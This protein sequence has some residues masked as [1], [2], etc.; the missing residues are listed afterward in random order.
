MV[1][2]ATQRVVQE[3]YKNHAKQRLEPSSNMSAKASIISCLRPRTRSSKVT[4]FYSRKYY[5]TRIKPYVWDV[6]IRDKVPPNEILS[7]I[8]DETNKAWERESAEFKEQFLKEH[9]EDKKEAITS[10]HSPAEF[11]K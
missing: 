3:W 5:D 2:S 9:E 10:D 7:V 8:R 1:V 11:H 4:E 6:L